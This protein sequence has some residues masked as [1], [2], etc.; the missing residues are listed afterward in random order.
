MDN[1]DYIDLNDVESDNIEVLEVPIKTNKFNIKDLFKSKK[2]LIGLIVVIILL[3]SVL[4]YFVFFYKKDDNKEDNKQPVVLKMNNYVYTDG[5]LTFLD[6]NDN[7]VGSYECSVKDKEKCYLGVQSK[8]EILDVV[9]HVYEDKSLVDFYLPYYNNLVFVYDDEVYK[10]Y[11][12]EKNEVIK[13]FLSIKDAGGKNL[14]AENSDNKFAVINLENEYK[15]VTGFSYDYIGYNGSSDGIYSFKKDGYNGILNEDGEE[16]VTKVSGDITNY[17]DRYYVIGSKLYNYKKEVL[18]EDVNV[19]KLYGEYIFAISNVV[20]PYDED[21]NKLSEL[22]VEVTTGTDLNDYVIYNKGLQLIKEDNLI[23]YKIDDKYIEIDKKKINVFEG[24]VSS[25]YKYVSYYDGILYYY[26]SEDKTNFIG[27]YECSNKNNIKSSDDVL[28]S[29]G[30]A[31]DVNLMVQTEEEA[32]LIPT[33]YDNYA[34]ITDTKPR[35]TKPNINLYDFGNGKTIVSYRFVDALDTIDADQRDIKKNS[36]VLLKN[37]KDGELLGIINIKDDKVE[38]FIPFNYKTITMFNEEYYLGVT[39]SGVKA[40][41]DL[42]GNAILKEDVN[43][44][45]EI[46][47]FDGSNI[48]SSINGKKQIFKVDGTI[49]SDTF[50]DIKM[51]KDIYVGI[52]S[53]EKISIYTYN[54][55]SVNLLNEDKDIEY[56]SFKVKELHDK[57]YS[58]SLYDNEVLVGTYDIVVSD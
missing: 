57:N 56:T 54:D 34:F 40:M 9:K 48:L 32:L 18:I 51:Y 37:T 58:V 38:P 15:E 11:D 22:G 30:P 19:I 2:F 17:N 36:K 41:Y 10:L 47:E 44:K 16:S 25:K 29:C 55:K 27:M 39:S 1:N 26:D 4:I 21:L 5:I 31:S 46:L 13:E 43:F 14:I 7:E 20:I 8:E 35:V 42:N 53:K 52:N 49:V 12:M 28:T 50:K 3:L 6:N 24:I 23:D 45:N 33:F